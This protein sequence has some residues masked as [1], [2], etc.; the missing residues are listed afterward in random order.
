MSRVLRKIRA[1]KLTED[2]NLNSPA[3]NVAKCSLSQGSWP[4]GGS[5]TLHASPS[6]KSGSPYPHFFEKGEWQVK[7]RVNLGGDA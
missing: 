7:Y 4:L 6:A 2:I 1:L 5:Q 3:S